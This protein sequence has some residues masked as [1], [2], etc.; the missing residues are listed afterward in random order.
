MFDVLVMPAQ[1]PVRLDPG[2]RGR[3]EVNYRSRFDGMPPKGVQQPPVDTAI[4]PGSGDRSRG[5]R[6]SEQAQSGALGRYAVDPVST[7]HVFGRAAAG[8]HRARARGRMQ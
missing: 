5:E 2:A 3:P 7:N 6:A 4:V 1:G 8:P